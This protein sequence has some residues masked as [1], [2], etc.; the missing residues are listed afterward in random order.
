MDTSPVATSTPAPAP[1]R[2][3]LWINLL[4]NAVFPAVILTTL[5]KEHRL[6]PMW[7]LIVAVSL[8]LTYGIYDLASRRKWNVFSVL[9]VISISLTGGFGL[10]KLSG[11]WFAIKEAAV[12]LVLGAAVPL[13]LHTRQPLVRI[14]VCN[15]QIMNMPKVEAALHAANAWPAFQALLRRVSWIIAGSFALSATLNFFLA[16]WILRS[17]SGTPEFAEELGRLTVLS[18]PVIT[19]P[20]MVVM[21]FALWKLIAG[22]EKLTGLSGEELFHDRRTKAP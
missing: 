11:L 14:L 4:C 5:S 10:F 22:L 1:P 21:M 3:N 8:P 17:P 16:L 2:E 18:Y 6:G 9:G 20:T 7:A 15:E 13:T 19:L 12:P